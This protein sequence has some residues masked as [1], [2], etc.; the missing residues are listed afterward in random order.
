ML[1]VNNKRMHILQ[2]LDQIDSSLACWSTRPAGVKDLG[3]LF[4][5]FGVPVV[6]AELVFV[7]VL[8][9]TEPSVA[10]HRMG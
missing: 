3:C 4:L 8:A 10:Y 1:L 7:A 6:V 2:T 9:Q 5:E